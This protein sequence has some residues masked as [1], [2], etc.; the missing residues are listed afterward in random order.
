MQLGLPSFQTNA[1]KMGLADCEFHSEG[2]A[3]R[4][5]QIKCK[6]F[7]E[8]IDY[9]VHGKFFDDSIGTCK[10]RQEETDLEADL[11]AWEGLD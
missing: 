5:A 11:I 9:F 3:S 2:K 7:V 10:L 8:Y 4:C 6:Y 1:E